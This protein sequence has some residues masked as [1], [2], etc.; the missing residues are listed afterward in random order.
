M[1]TAPVQTRTH[2]TRRQV[3]LAALAARPLLAIAGVIGPPL[4]ARAAA[5]DYGVTTVDLVW[6]EMPDGVK[7]AARLWLPKGASNEHFPCVFE[8]IPYRTHDS[9]RL[10]DDHWGLQLA[11]GGI[12]FARVDIRGSGNSEG[13]LADEYLGLEQAD[14]AATIAWLARQSWCNGNIGMRGISW[15][16]FSALQVAA[17]APPALKAIMPMCATDMRFRNDAHYVG[18]RRVFD[19]HVRPARSRGGWRTLG[20]H[21]AR[22]A[23]KHARHRSAVD[24]A[25]NQRCLLAPRVGR[26]RSGG[27]PL[28]GLSGRWL[29]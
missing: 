2:L 1:P 21:V 13:L 23:G 15:G 26:D 16:G 4:P 5:A 22:T 18:G 10:I 25:P 17:L 19:G 6:V 24:A 11:A 9:Y 27:D 12:A 8:Y 7:L 14:G 3:V 29:G 20:Y 28:R